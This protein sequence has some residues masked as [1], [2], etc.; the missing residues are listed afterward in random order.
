MAFLGALLAA[1]AI[2]AAILV[3]NRLTPINFKRILSWP[4]PD[5]ASAGQT[6]TALT[7]N[8]GYG[9]L[10][11]GA[12]FFVDGGNNVRAL[13]KPAITRATHWISTYLAGA[14]ADVLL[15][16]EAATPSFL[17][18]GVDIRGALLD[19]LPHLTA[20]FW[21]DFRT[22]LVPPPLRVEHGMASFSRLQGAAPIVLPMPQ[23]P[24]YH[25]GFLKKYYAA[26]VTSFPIAG[27]DQQ[28]VVI[29]MHLSAFDPGAATRASQIGALFD[30]AQAAYARGDFVIIGGDWNMRLADVDFPHQTDARHLHWIHDMP[31]TSL[32]QGWQWGVDPRTPTVRTMNQPYVPGENFTMVIDGFAVSPN[33]QIDDVT[34]TDLA[35]EHT[36]HH[37]VWGRFSTRPQI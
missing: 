6:L 8:I 15:I 4:A 25:F 34:T 1:L 11:A 32:P 27:T 5:P 13:D 28:W 21:A 26:L 20:H 29:N 31:D 14:E 9:S 3:G 2:C 22:Y 23:D 18:R 36:D 17:T 12:D 16:Q 30:Y 19:H 7:W 24:K 35:F 33:V 37:P 10:G